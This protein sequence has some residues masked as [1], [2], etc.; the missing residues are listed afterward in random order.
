MIRQDSSVILAPMMALR[1]VL[2]VAL[3]AL[4]SANQVD[5]LFPHYTPPVCQPGPLTASFGLSLHKTQFLR[6]SDDPWLGFGRRS[7]RAAAPHGPRW[8]SRRSGP[9]GP[10]S[11]PFGGTL[12]PMPRAQYPRLPCP[13]TNSYSPLSP[14]AMLVSALLG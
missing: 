11:S 2:L 12:R 4:T 10:P 7:A 13:V 14:P 5:V 3:P 8:T 1:S 9:M 6:S